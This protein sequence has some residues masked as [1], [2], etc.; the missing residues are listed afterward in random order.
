MLRGHTFAKENRFSLSI[1]FYSSFVLR[2]YLKEKKYEKEKQKTF[3][4]FE[5]GISKDGCHFS[6]FWY[7]YIFLVLPITIYNLYTSK[8]LWNRNIWNHSLYIEV[9]GYWLGRYQFH[10]RSFSFQ[11]PNHKTIIALKAISV[12]IGFD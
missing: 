2:R 1:S 7:E 3:I 9:D 11:I 12:T 8:L 10:V 5:Q 4:T 6:C